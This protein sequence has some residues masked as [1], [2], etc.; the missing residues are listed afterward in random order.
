IGLAWARLNTAETCAA[1][2]A[3]ALEGDIKHRDH[4]K[5]DGAGGDHP[6]KDGRT[7]IVAADLGGALRDDQ[8]VNPKDEGEGGLKGSI[9]KALDPK[10]MRQ[11]IAR[12]HAL[13]EAEATNVGART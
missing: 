4:E 7:D 10:D 13:I 5:P 1:A 6:G 11:D 8:G 12:D 3:Q 2:L 9:G